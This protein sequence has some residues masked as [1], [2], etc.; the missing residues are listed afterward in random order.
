MCGS[1]L[2]ELHDEECVAHLVLLIEGGLFNVRKKHL[3]Q[4]KVTNIL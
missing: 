4:T 1:C 2:A 3:R